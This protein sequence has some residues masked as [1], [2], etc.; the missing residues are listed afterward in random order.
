MLE[1]REGRGSGLSKYPICPKL[2]IQKMCV[3]WEKFSSAYIVDIVH[4]T[5]LCVQGL[6]SILWLKIAGIF[7]MSISLKLSVA[8]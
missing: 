2:G 7:Y 3:Q 8:W 4:S 6:I 1:R 5:W